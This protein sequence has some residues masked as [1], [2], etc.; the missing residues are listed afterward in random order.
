MKNAII[1]ARVSTEDQALNGVSLENQIERCKAYC[2]LNELIPFNIIS[3][4]G[5][6]G[7]DLNREGI[8]QLIKLCEDKQI[9][10]V[11]IYKLDR[12]SRSLKDILYLITDIF[13]AH[14]IELH[15]I[16]EKLDT[17]T[18]MGE[19]FVHMT[20]ALSQLERSLISE[21]TKDA[22]RKVKADGVY[23]GQV[24]FGYKRTGEGKLEE[25][26][27]EIEIVNRARY[28]KE[29]LG[30]SLNSIALDLNRLGYR[31]KRGEYFSKQ[32]VRRLLK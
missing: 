4:P 14:E 22:L 17:G 8:Q 32:S 16:Q 20:G 27:R 11:V 1:Y 15:S 24:P 7:K 29:T 30:K 18:A 19:F 23:L 25:N 10:A 26:E 9:K 2:K 31:T 6:S 21:R 28:C 5:Q 12:L 13:K 3:D